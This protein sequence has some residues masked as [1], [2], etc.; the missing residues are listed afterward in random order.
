MKGGFL[1]DDAT[2]ALIVNDPRLDTPTVAVDGAELVFDDAITGQV[3]GQGEPYAP[4][5]NVWPA[6]YDGITYDHAA[7][8]I[9]ADDGTP[10]DVTVGS[11][12]AARSLVGA[13][14]LISG[15]IN[16]GGFLT[17]AQ[18][19]V[20]QGNGNEMKCHSATHTDLSAISGL[21]A[22][23]TAFVAETQG[24]QAALQ[25]LG[26]F[27]DA[28]TEPGPWGT[29]DPAL[30]LIDSDAKL[31]GRAGRLI[32][33]L[34]AAYYSYNAITN[35][36]SGMSAPLP[37]ARRYGVARQAVDS[38]ALATIEG[39]VD[40]LVTYGGGAIL[41]IHSSSLDQPGKLTTADFTAL[42]DY[43]QTKRDA[44]QL[45]V[46][47]PTGLLYARQ[48][49]RGKVNLLSD[50]NLALSATGAL[51]GSW[52]VAGGA[53]TVVPFGRTYNALQCNTAN[54][55]YL[56]LA[57]RSGTARQSPYRSFRWEVWAKS[58]VAGSTAKARIIARAIDTNGVLQYV[59]PPDS[60]SVTVGDT[61]TKV[62][63]NC[64][65]HPDSR[66]MRLLLTQ[67]A[68][69]ASDV[70]YSDPILHKI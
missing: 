58:A 51:R 39:Y 49:T 4:P 57:L 20:L 53:P 64:S 9:D 37:A 19:Q 38:T 17:T 61:W 60:G 41:N 15:S 3:L 27:A 28:F 59:T 42:L 6:Q 46:L 26:F 25:A 56:L 22:Q 14:G 7:L 2:G 1:R 12:L 70:V 16:T 13:F 35:I 40:N 67:G 69:S 21:A 32:R 18:A 47:T 11:L 45:D 30:W 62:A 33:R 44:G 63:L 52:S 50:A 36:S 48:S 29:A 8:A 23:W 68:A 66:F 5:L 55:A 10:N 24:A 34:F 65:S 54:T 31:A 43:I